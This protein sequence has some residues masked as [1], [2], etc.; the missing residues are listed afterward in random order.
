MA[1]MHTTI[2]TD[3]TQLEAHERVGCGSHRLQQGGMRSAEGRGIHHTNDESEP[4]EGGA[5][6]GRIL[7]G[8]AT[9][10]TI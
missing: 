2:A 5:T 6:D 8:G 7:S 9:W 4:Q 1:D 10:H 3:Q